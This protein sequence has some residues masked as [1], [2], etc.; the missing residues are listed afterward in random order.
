METPLGKGIFL[1]ANP[2][3]RDP[4][5]RQ[6]V[7]LLCEHGREGALGVVVNRPT[8]INI[9]EVLPQVPILEGQHH[10]VYAGGPVQQNNLLILYRIPEGLEDTHHVF[11]GVYLGG[12]MNVV[13]DLVQ[14][15]SSL[16]N[17][18]AFIGYSGWAPGQLEHEMQTGSW[19]T[20]PADPTT[21]FETDASRLWG[22]I[23][24]SL[25]KDFECYADMPVDPHMN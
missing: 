24:R 9:T 17:F 16:E 11:D 20:L 10:M 18:R 6:A 15:P 22:N 5:F 1:V 8:K 12:N 19:F 23:L 25:S 4:N 14:N 3:L 21:M 2:S 13:K 7:I